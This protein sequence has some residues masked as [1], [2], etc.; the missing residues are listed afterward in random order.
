MGDYMFMCVFEERLILAAFDAKITARN[1]GTCSAP[2]PVIRLVAEQ[3]RL[4]S[5]STRIRWCHVFCQDSAWTFFQFISPQCQCTCKARTTNNAQCLPFGPAPGNSHP[6]PPPNKVID[7]RQMRTQ[8][9]SKNVSQS[10]PPP[11]LATASPNSIACPNGRP[12][13]AEGPRTGKENERKWRRKT[14]WKEVERRRGRN[15][16]KEKRIAMRETDK[17]AVWTF[18]LRIRLLFLGKKSKKMLAE[19]Y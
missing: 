11:P 7:P 13:F 15:R 6:P 9:M 12:D 2:N 18:S 14:K 10:T 8:K 4:P 3:H 1:C 5:A 17:M 19:N 16:G